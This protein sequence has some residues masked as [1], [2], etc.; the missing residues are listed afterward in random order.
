[1]KQSATTNNATRSLERL[2]ITL[3]TDAAFR[4]SL[5]GSILLSIVTT[6][7]LLLRFSH[8]PPVIP[9]FYSLPWGE[10]QLAAPQILVVVVAGFSLLYVLNFVIAFFLYT[11]FPF[12]ARLI[13]VGTLLLALLVNFSLVQI[14]LL[15]T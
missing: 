11:V 4:W 8:L 7:F 15:V 6:V 9:L 5:V 2:R 12:F 3:S 14:L 10:A 1:M 13:C